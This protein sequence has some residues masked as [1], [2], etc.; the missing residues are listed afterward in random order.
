MST[1]SNSLVLDPP[2][3]VGNCISDA[4]SVFEPS[5]HAAGRIYTPN[6]RTLCSI[7][8]MELT[9]YMLHAGGRKQYHIPS[10]PKG[11]YALL[12][13]YDTYTLTRNLSKIAAAGDED[14]DRADEMQQSPVFCDGVA[15][16]LIRMW[17]GDAPGN[18]SGAKPGIMVLADDQ[19]TQLE[20]DQLN[21]TQTTYFRWLVM[22][23]DEY[24]I[25]GD[26]KSI[27]D[28]HRRALRW[29][30]SEDREWYKKID[31][32]LLKRCPA[33]AEEV[34]MMA[35]VC[36]YCQT[37]LI[38]W[39]KDVGFEPEEKDD[40]GVFLFFKALHER[41]AP[42]KQKE[43]EERMHQTVAAATSE[44]EVD[45][46]EAIARAAALGREA[47]ARAAAQRPVSPPVKGR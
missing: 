36:R 15:D 46:K 12:R 18:Q 43:A 14:M 47:D 30:G 8:P 22:K 3:P 9:H 38:K 13:V 24:W 20:L 27:T 37:N 23:G 29:L 19:P 31:A 26:R 21:D 32:V 44:S 1:N 10:V 2:I 7:Y 35:T 17:A 28:D 45:R 42:A 4:A 6:N 5:P 34:N 40:M 16:D 41:E 39:Y 11:T 25:T 33:C